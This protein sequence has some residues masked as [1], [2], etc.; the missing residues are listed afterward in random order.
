MSNAESEDIKSILEQNNS[1]LSRAIDAVHSCIGQWKT[2]YGLTEAEVERFRKAVNALHRSTAGAMTRANSAHGIAFFLPVQRNE[3]LSVKGLR[4]GL[5]AKALLEGEQRSVEFS[6]QQSVNAC[7]IADLEA[8]WAKRMSAV[9]IQL[10]SD[11]L[12]ADALES[13]VPRTAVNPANINSSAAAVTEQAAAAAGETTQA[14][15]NAGADSSETVGHTPTGDSAMSDDPPRAARPRSPRTPEPAVRK[16]DRPRRPLIEIILDPRSIQALI[17][18]GGALMTAGLVILLYLN[19]FFTP[20]IMATSLAVSN[21]T[22]LTAG[23]GIIRLTRYQLAGRSLALLACLLMPLN[24]WYCHTQNLITIEGNLWVLAVIVSLLYGISAWVLKDELFVYVFNAGVT[25]TGLLFIASMHPSPERFLEIATPATLLVVLGLLN[26]H[27]LKAFAID[28]S[29]DEQPEAFSRQRFGMAFFWSGHLQLASGLLLILIAQVAGDWLYDIWFRQLYVRWQAIPSPV[30][31]EQRWLALML[32]GL[33]TWGWI[34]SDLFV[35]RR[36]AFLQMAA[37]GFIWME[38]LVIQ[39]L[40]LQ[41][42]TDLIIAVLSVTSLLTHLA[43]ASLNH[44]SRSSASLPWIGLVM[45]L[46][47]TCIGT[48]IFVNH[49]SLNLQ[50]EGF[51]R[52]T[53]IGA[54]LL[55]AVA[56]RTGAHFSR[57]H[58]PRILESWFFG[59]AGAT[60]ISV[61]AMLAYGGLHQWNQQAPLV[62]L[63]P[64]AWLAASK[65]YGVQPQSNSLYHISHAG[66]AALIV[67]SLASLLAVFLGSSPSLSDFLLLSIFSAEVAIFYGITATMKR[68]RFFA[69]LSTAAWCVSI[70]LLLYWFGLS[71]RTFIIGFATFGLMMLA[72]CRLSDLKVIPA[73]IKPI[74]APSAHG[75]LII[76]LTSAFFNVMFDVLSENIAQLPAAT[77]IMFSFSMLLIGTAASVITSTDGLRRCYAVIASGQ[78]LLAMLL[79]YRLIDLSFWQ[80]VE[81]ISV[82]TGV[83]LLAV[84]HF[85]WYREQDEESD[86]ASSALLFGSI[87]TVAPLAIATLIDRNVGD[88]LILNELGFLFA[89]ITLLALGILFRL[90]STTVLGALAT[91]VYFVSL[92]LFVPWG[93][94]STVA[95]AI[96]TGGTVIFGTG[97]ILAF[98]RDR[99]LTLPDRM[100]KHEGLFRV[101]GWR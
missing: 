69:H 81:V 76:A 21:I 61:I 92:A 8:N 79:L 59:T 20:P 89:S 6:S 72:L 99:L 30:C 11:G 66:C 95:I 26:I 91:A 74:L 88:F 62:M 29:G 16:P 82:I 78:G 100:R 75:I 25:M 15:A 9:R 94:I 44:M 36:G 34:Y 50:T 67:P 55:S 86:L 7:R 5:L 54:M 27:L 97:L 80:K 12:D 85:A 22:L 32:V 28:R 47:P 87:L 60:L 3:T 73:G 56:C 70:G 17:G 77:M 4:A 51:P 33:G 43:I 2:Q 39:I 45:G 24:L 68:E 42:S 40:G 52:L 19:N 38:F 64:L 13:L 57:Q 37:F 84:G 41:A 101:L 93:Q 31:G 71:A 46:L 35:H 14:S 98:F 23:L 90:R 1:A 58:P 49:F 48:V 18:V 63:V 65:H 10:E 83:L 53:F 96:M